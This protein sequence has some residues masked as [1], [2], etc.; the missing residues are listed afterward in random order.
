MVASP[1]SS[2]NSL[3][4][5]QTEPLPW[6]VDATP[7]INNGYPVLWWQEQSEPPIITR[8]SDTQTSAKISLYP[9]PATTMI[10]LHIE[11]VDV[12]EMTVEIIDLQGR[13]TD[14]L[15]V[16]DN[17]VFI[18]LGCYAKGI[19]L[20]RIIGENHSFDRIEKLIIK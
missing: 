12:K 14:R 20:V 6:K 5:G 10:I 13:L 8:L 1:G 3:N 16:K 7:N 11:G 4:F 17:P 2:K 15:R 18:D 19:Y 9:N